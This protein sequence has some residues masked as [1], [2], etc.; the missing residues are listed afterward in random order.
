MRK[1]L[2]VAVVIAVAFAGLLALGGGG[3]AA[4]PPG[5]TPGPVLELLGG[6]T[7]PFA[8]RADLGA[9]RF[10]VTPAVSQVVPVARADDTRR[11]ARFTLESGPAMR[12]TYDC[13]VAGRSGCPATVCLVA[14]GVARPAGCPTDAPSRPSGGLVV[15]DV[16]GT[17]RFEAPGGPAVAWQR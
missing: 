3:T 7:A 8:A 9:R 10:T 15:Q 12:I 2:L 5:Y 17:V 6:L 14:E 11:V 4:P 1:L 13:G 16:G